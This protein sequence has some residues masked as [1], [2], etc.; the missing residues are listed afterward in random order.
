MKERSLKPF[1]LSRRSAFSLIEL[2]VVIGIIALLIGLLLPAV[3]RV[4]HSAAR[5]QCQNNL[6]QIGLAAHNAEATRGTLPPG[7]GY[8]I[9]KK[10]F[11]TF[12]FFLLPYLEQNSLYQQSFYAG[13]H[14]VGNSQVYAQPVS[15]FVCPSDPSAPRTG[16]ATD[17]MGITW[18]VATY[19][20]N[21]QAVGNTSSDGQMTDAEK[22]ARIP[23]SFSD[24]TS[25]TILMT[26]KYAQCFNNSYPG[27]GNFWAYYFNSTNLF[28]YHPGYAISWN[29]YCY[30]TASKFQSQPMPYNGGCD[31]TLASSP[32]SG[33]IAVGMV[34]GSVRFVSNEVSTFTWWY[35]TTP[36][37]GE[38]IQ[39]DSF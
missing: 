30:G 4:R 25:N 8:D 29:S 9:G 2:L 14:F 13:F 36:M 3:Q 6:K 19:A 33:G 24:G 18:G 17:A 32:H 12:H 10:A 20:V 11:G 15:A 26:E 37:G 27:G 16:V 31:P 39:S 5:L 7:L 1:V 22:Y 35:L 34:D 23:A 38:T 28:P 21:A